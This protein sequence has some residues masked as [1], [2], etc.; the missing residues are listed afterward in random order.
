MKKSRPKA[1]PIDESPEVAAEAPPE[2]QV[3]QGEFRPQ[4][5]SGPFPPPALLREFD[6]IVT[7]GAE[8]LF[9]QFEVEA[10]H[11]RVL[12]S[13]RARAEA[14]ERRIAQYVAIGFAFGV[15]LVSGLALAVGAYLPAS[16]IG[17]GA[18]LM[19]VASY[20][21]TKLIDRAEAEQE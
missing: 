14:R 9:R 10:S 12:E 21:G 2:P 6:Q 20:I 15:L 4:Q 5:W 3:I 19:V 17:G 11:R 7:G 16:V 13:T 1:S 8:R 18:V